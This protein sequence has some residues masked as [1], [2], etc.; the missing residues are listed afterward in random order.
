MENSQTELIAKK[1]SSWSASFGLWLSW[2]ELNGRKMVFAINVILIA[3]F[4]ALPVSLD[5]MG[6]A[7][8]SSIG[9]RIDYIGPSLILVPEGIRSSDLVTAQLK[10]STYSS[11]IFNKIQRALSPY[12]R[13]AEARL[14]V[15]LFIE[16]REMPVTGI[17]FQ[18]VYSYPFARY[19][20]GNDDVLLG[21]IASEKLHKEKDDTLII[22]SHTFTVADIIPTAGGI[23]DVSVFLPLPVLQK[24]AKQDGRINEIRLFPRSVSSYEELK[25]KLREY[26]GGLNL[27]DI[28][29]G[30]TAEKDIDSTLLGFQKALYAVA[31]IL[32]ALCIMIST[33]INLDGR[34]SEVS[35]VYTLGATQAFIFQILIFRTIWITLLGSFI[36]H[37]IAL[38][39]TVIQDHNVPLRFIWSTGSFIE[40]VLGAVFLGVF[41]TIPFAVYSLYKRDFLSYL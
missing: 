25:L 8:K 30:D 1:T 31:F 13:N 11:S 36:G 22:D 37:F 3:L 33:Y 19:S 12:L 4:I 34:K 16:G 39:V 28:Y 7:R 5:L 38:L 35:T 24:L 27:I 6:N 18:G 23:D 32:I 41:V 26:S 15:R 10:G 40:V 9:S 21:T 2:Q 20:I 29:R 14:T 17:D